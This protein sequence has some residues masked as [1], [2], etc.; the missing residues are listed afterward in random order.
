MIPFIK[1][2]RNALLTPKARRARKIGLSREE[3]RNFLA[4]PEGALHLKKLQLAGTL[5]KV[6]FLKESKAF[7]IETVLEDTYHLEKIKLPR[8]QHVTIVDVGA[9]VGAFAIAARNEFP[10]A[11]IHCYEP[12]PKLEPNLKMQAYAVG[13][14]C[15]MEGVG[16]QSGH[17]SFDQ[18]QNET[19]D[20]E[21]VSIVDF[22]KAGNVEIVSLAQ[23]I[24]RIGGKVD[25]LKLDCEGSEWPILKDLESLKKVKYLAME[26][27]RM[28]GDGS[29]DQYD[30]SI[31]IQRRAI[32]AVEA[33]GFK[34]QIVKANTI[35]AGIIVACREP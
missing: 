27:H 20:S 24:E 11:T 22:T 33:A 34:I 17:F 9:N 30:R 21:S 13:A 8:D 31:D 32:E 5:K 15:F 10:L 19:L 12:N 35:D 23:V 14:K 18:Q 6:S 28:C 29:F 2:L 25:L 26:Y 16:A 4:D 3:L 7:L 1:R